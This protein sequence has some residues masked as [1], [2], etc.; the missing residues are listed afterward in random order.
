MVSMPYL[1]HLHAGRAAKVHGNFPV[2][3]HP[4]HVVV[5]QGK[6][7]RRKVGILNELLH[8][9][10]GPR[11]HGIVQTH[12][13]GAG[14]VA[15]S[16]AP[17]A[18][19]RSGKLG[20][21]KPLQRFH[22]VVIVGI[23][24]GKA[25]DAYRFKRLTGRHKACVI[26]RQRDI[27]LLKK[28]AVDHKAVGIRTHRQPVHTAVLVFKAVEVGVVHS[29][30]LVG[31]GKV[32]QTV[33]QRGSIVQREPA[34]GDDIRQAAVLLQKLVKIQIVVAYDELNIHVRQLRLDIG[35]IAFV[36][37]IAPQ[38]HL[39]GLGILLLLYL[40]R[41]FCAAAGQQGQPQRQ[42]RKHG[43][44]AAQCSFVRQI[45]SP[46]SSWAAAVFAAKL[47]WLTNRTSPPARV[48]ALKPAHGNDAAIFCV[49]PV[50]HFSF[51]AKRHSAIETYN[52]FT[53]IRKF[54]QQ[55]FTY[56]SIK[57]TRIRFLCGSSGIVLQ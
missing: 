16:G 52:Y 53:I 9:L 39:N 31:Q 3:E 8:P 14:G 27:V 12:P 46:H 41:A 49:L 6:V 42:Y 36:Q 44:K 26:G 54:F 51:P 37:A 22:A 15:V 34:A 57:T 25:P 10:K 45:H 2:A 17:L 50:L 1:K 30:R 13:H 11:P 35:S 4:G 20:G 32:H 18:P 48:C 28:A 47:L 7:V 56:L 43:N 23:V 19:F 24:S 38:I 21:G 33:F 40:F 55:I 29:A 5:G